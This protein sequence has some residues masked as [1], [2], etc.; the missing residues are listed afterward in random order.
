MAIEM[1]QKYDHTE[2]ERG[3]YDF[4]LKNNLFASGDMMK[5]PFTIVIPPPNITG[6]LHLG[7]CWNNTLQD[8]IIRRKRMQG[9]DALYLPGMDHAGIATQARVDQ[10]LREQG[11]DRFHLGREKYLKEAWNWKKEHA[12]FIREQWRTMGLSLDYNLE[13]FTLDQG[14]SKAVEKVFIALYNKGYIYRGVRII[15]WDVEAKTAL[16]NIEI[17]HEETRGTM[18]YYDYPLA[19]GSGFVTVA[20]TRPETMF[21]DTA[22][23][24]HPDDGRYHHLHGKLVRIPTTERTIPIIV[25]TFVDKEFGTGAVKVT[26]AHDPNDFVVGKRHHLEMPLCMNED[27]TMNQLAGRFEGMERFACRKAVVA[28]LD[29]LG[30]LKKTEEIIHS[31]GHSE[32]T[33]IIIEPRLSKQWFVAMKELA[34][35]ALEKSTVEF[36]PERFRKMYENWMSELEDW[37]ISRQLWW[38]HRLPVWYKGDEVFCGHEAPGA[39]WVQDED[40]LDTWFSSALWPFSTLGWPDEDSHLYQ[41][42]YPTDVLVTAYDIIFFWV[43]R[44]IFTGI[45]FTGKSPFRQCLIHGL[46]RDSEGR[47]MSKSLGN[48]VDPIDVIEDYGA[49]ALRYF[50]ATNSALGQDLRYEQE[51]VE[52]SWNY[53]NKIWNI[54]RYVLQV[55]DKHGDPS[56]VLEPGQLSFADKWIIHRL[57]RML[58][59]ADD[60]LERYEFGEAAKVIYNFTWDDFASWYLEMSKVDQ[61]N[62]TTRRVLLDVLEAI[63]KLNHPFMP[64]VTEDI[65]QRLPGHKLSIMTADWPTQNRMEFPE[66]ENKEYFFE[67]IKQLRQ[68]RNQYQVAYQKPI[69]L[70]VEGNEET[71]EF[72][73]GNLQYLEKFC[74]IGEIVYLKQKSAMKK[75]IAIVFHEVSFYVPLGSLIDEDA[76]LARLEKVQAD[77]EA[78]IKRAKGL[79]ANPGFLGKA[80][81]EKIEQEEQKLALYERRLLETINNIKELTK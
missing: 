70:F 35:N 15:N 77:L 42:Y 21:A 48:G 73:H 20:T 23:M 51:K 57:N 1:K 9:Y 17:E 66:T 32:R 50:I 36:I 69:P 79:L 12:D 64:F 78:E 45:E 56:P 49:D 22:L 8:I 5:K 59:Q 24:V 72:I 76:E 18:Y 28:E 14:L 27:G 31:I 41:R 68:L 2:V 67:L 63:L 3:K 53:I 16:S 10:K 80:P 39:D 65:Y 75:T 30:L 6:K 13:R 43:A 61:D 29:R 81:K 11:I 40:V 4:W 44:M 54:S 37:C 46:I 7:H 47:K 71:N 33:G 55:L 60:L 34:G 52:S 38:G 74:N 26:P 19:D 58:Q 25:D 62:P